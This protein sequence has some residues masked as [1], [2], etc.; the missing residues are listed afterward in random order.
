MY[1]SQERLLVAP[2]FV[3]RLLHVPQ[4]DRRSKASHLRGKVRRWLRTSRPATACSRLLLRV[5]AWLFG[6]WPG[7]S[8]ARKKQ[9]GIK[10]KFRSP[11]I[12]LHAEAWLAAQRVTCLQ[13][14]RLGRPMPDLLPDVSTPDMRESG[15][16][17]F[18]FLLRPI[19]VLVCV[20]AS[21]QESEPMRW[22]T[23]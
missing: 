10:D 15:K 19:I 11:V 4:D 18:C 9:A 5:H 6:L 3:Q 21:Q 23:A 14:A 13:D 17:F 8:V 22:Y 20:S 2:N 12:R 1:P 7:M 16:L